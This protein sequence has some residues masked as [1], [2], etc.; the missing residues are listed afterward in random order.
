[1]GALA[2][3]W[4]VGCATMG[5]ADAPDDP[6]D[7]QIDGDEGAQFDSIDAS[8]CVSRSGH[9]YVLWLDD[10]RQGGGTLDL[11]MNR[12]L[13]EPTRP[14]SWLP[15]PVRVSQGDGSVANPA[16]HCDDTGVYAVWEAPHHGAQENHQIWFNRSVDQGRTFLEEDRLVEHDVDGATMSL[17]PRIL[18]RGAALMVAWMDSG[19]GAYDILVSRSADRGEHWA[20]PIRVDSD[21]PG[22]AYSARPRVAMSDDGRS[23]WVAWE[24]ARD[25]GAD[26]YVARSASGGVRFLPD[27]RVD[28][29]D[30]PGSGS[31]SGPVL[32]AGDASNVSVV[33]RESGP[34][35]GIFINHS[36]D[37]GA[38]WSR[39][40]LAAQSDVA[41]GTISGEPR[42]VA[43][44]AVTHVAWVDE[45]NGPFDVFY[46]RMVAGVFE[47]GEI[48]ASLPEVPSNA[49]APHLSLDPESGRAAVAWV[50]DR[51]GGQGRVEGAVYY[52]YFEGGGLAQDDQDYRVDAM[53]GDVVPPTS[54]QFEVRGA[55]WFAAW[56]DQRGL[57][58]D[59]RVQSAPLGVETMPRGPAQLGM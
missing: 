58:S 24:D 50:D 54:V 43:D 17:A 8:M 7:V 41:V 56:I 9:A 52:Q 55:Q 51:S 1:M 26:I 12:A 20:D 31:S 48:V 37:G 44:G 14:E 21:R 38:T 53:F 35:A 3:V 5:S 27:E 10:R 18:G 22:A 36:S 4:V 19:A 29:G 47:A 57:T 28:L 30:A 6:V 59:V 15:T 40:A 23:R 16:V 34:P 42:C 2:G 13:S 39:E 25:G 32:C 46:R 11:W 45:R 49:Y 33:W